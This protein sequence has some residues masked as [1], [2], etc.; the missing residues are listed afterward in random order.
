MLPKGGAKFKALVTGNLG[1]LETFMFSGAR[2]DK[3][4]LFLPKN[5]TR[6]NND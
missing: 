3:I 4:T 5:S 2:D 1:S 6:N